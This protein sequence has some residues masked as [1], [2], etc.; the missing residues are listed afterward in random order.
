MHWLLQPIITEQ[1]LLRAA[2]HHTQIVTSD[3]QPP[4]STL[5]LQTNR[6]DGTGRFQPTSRMYV[7]KLSARL[8]GTVKMYLGPP[9]TPYSC[10]RP[11]CSNCNL[12]S[13]WVP[14]CHCAF[15]DRG[16]I[17]FTMIAD[18][19]ARPSTCI[20]KLVGTLFQK[21]AGR[22]IP[23]GESTGSALPFGWD[24]PAPKSAIKN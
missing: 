24:A 20:A 8:A 19:N 4:A 16:N 13:S 1:P 14:T 22:N 23:A 17:A 21:M 2:S 7:Q 10:K 15:M 9:L 5:Q 12:A 18:G 11:L 3:K 6:N